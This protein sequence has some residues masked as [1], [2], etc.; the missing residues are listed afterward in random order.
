MVSF[1]WKSELNRDDKI[2]FGY[3]AQE[4]EKIY[5]NMVITDDKGYKSVNYTEL[6]VK[7]LSDLE[8]EVAALKQ[9]LNNK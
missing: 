3:V 5:P 7:K 8:Q 9:Q 6:L 2:H 1:T 4:V